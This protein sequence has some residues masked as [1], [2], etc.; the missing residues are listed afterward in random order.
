MG[1]SSHG[2]K[3]SSREQISQF[4]LDR[5]S[6]VAC[7]TDSR[8]LL[9]DLVNVLCPGL[10]FGACRFILL[11]LFIVEVNVFSRGLRSGPSQNRF[12]GLAIELVDRHVERWHCVLIG[13][14][15]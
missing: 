5:E 10:R 12:G 13:R 14:C 3:L 2:S 4:K 8:R 7:V 1:T 9:L 15:E 11:K 6:L